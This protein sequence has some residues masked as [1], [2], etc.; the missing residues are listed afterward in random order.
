MRFGLQPES[1]GFSREISSFWRTI[2]DLALR[3]PRDIVNPAVIGAIET[4][5]GISLLNLLERTRGVAEPD[6]IYMLIASGA[7]YVDLNV[8]PIAEPEQVRVFATT[9]IA[10]AC[11]V[12]SRE[13]FVGIGV[14]SIDGR[15]CESTDVHSE[16]FLLLAA[17]SELD[18][19]IANRRFDTCQATSRGGS[20]VVQHA[21]QNIAPLDSAV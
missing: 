6:E 16:A 13:S 19:A 21:G 10:A 8:A 20:A 17:A 7:I 2:C 3:I 18:L 5:P 1:T 9:E 14:R 12:V 4:E 15:L 11:E